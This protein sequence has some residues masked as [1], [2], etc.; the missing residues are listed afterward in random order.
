M[1][2]KVVE[3]K[4]MPFQVDAV[5]LLSNG[6]IAISGGPAHFE[7]LIYRHNL[8]AEGNKRE[9]MV[10]VDSLDTGGLQV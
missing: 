10:V 8:R 9:G 7:V 1:R 6:D 3:A 5:L 2:A 4:D